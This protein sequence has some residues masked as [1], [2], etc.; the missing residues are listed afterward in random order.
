MSVRS[1]PRPEVISRDNFGEELDEARKTI[2]EWLDQGMNA[3]DIVVLTRNHKLLNRL[4]Q[5]LNDAGIAVQALTGNQQ[6]RSGRVQLRT[7]HMAKGMEFRA[8]V[9]FGVGESYLP[10]KIGTK[11][12]V[13]AEYEDALQKERSLLYVAATRARDELVVLYSGKASPLLP[14]TQS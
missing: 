4:D 13:D 14:A 8:V 9:L 6:V 7:M 2:Q 11:N 1:G 10:D 12:L 3:E 5:G